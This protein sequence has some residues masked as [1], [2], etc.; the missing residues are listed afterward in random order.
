MS[1][2][3]SRKP[4]PK[5]RILSFRYILILSSHLHLGLPNSLVSS[6][7]FQLKFYKHIFS[8]SCLFNVLCFFFFLF[9][10][11][12]LYPCT[13]IWCNFGILFHIHIHWVSG[14]P[15]NKFHVSRTVLQKISLDIIIDWDAV[16]VVRCIVKASV[17]TIFWF[18]YD[19]RLCP[20]FRHCLEPSS[21]FDFAAFL[22]MQQKNTVKIFPSM[23]PKRCGNL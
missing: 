7:F 18:Y 2:C 20:D 15:R 11:V 9:I 21:A 10:L 13:V 22:A 16:F 1:F 17:L 6:F 8:L 3:I 12:L 19:L 4:I 5:S 14:D 23:K